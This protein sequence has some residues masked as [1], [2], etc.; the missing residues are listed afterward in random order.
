MKMWLLL[1]L[2]MGM[3]LAL[4]ELYAHYV[5]IQHFHNRN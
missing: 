2:G 3:E 1:D 4:R 5:R